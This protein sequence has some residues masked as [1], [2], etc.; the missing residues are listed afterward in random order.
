MITKEENDRLTQIGPGTLMGNLMRR[1][2]QP[3]IAA[4]A[5][6][7]DPVQPV[8]LL[9]EDL[10]I[11]RDEAG[12]LGLVAQRCAHRGSRLRTVSP[13]RMACAAL[14]T[15]G[16]TTRRGRSWTCPSSRRACL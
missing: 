1:Y 11:Y 15:A 7:E 4:A 8:R 16:L 6:D 12:K 5:L 13:K 14:T 2:W 10:V 3:V 9:G